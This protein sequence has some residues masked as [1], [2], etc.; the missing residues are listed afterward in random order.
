[1]VFQHKSLFNLVGSM[2]E[3]TLF[4]VRLKIC[5]CI[6]QADKMPEQI[7]KSARAAGMMLKENDISLSNELHFLF[8]FEVDNSYMLFQANEDSWP[9]EML[10]SEKLSLRR[11]QKVVFPKIAEGRYQAQGSYEIMLQLGEFMHQKLSENVNVTDLEVTAV[12]NSLMKREVGKESHVK[13]GSKRSCEG[14]DESGSSG[15]E[16]DIEEGSSSPDLGVPPAKKAK[17]SSQKKDT[18]VAKGGCCASCG[19]ADGDELVVEKIMHVLFR[20]EQRLEKS[21]DVQR[22]ILIVSKKALK[23]VDSMRES[24]TEKS[25]SETVEPSE[26]VYY[27]EKCLTDLGGETPEERVKRVARKLWTKQELS[28]IVIDP[29]KKIRPSETGRGEADIERQELFRKAAK[30]VLGKDYTKKLYRRCVRLV[31]VMGNGYKNKGF[32]KDDDE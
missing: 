12:V 30:T 5:F 28:T 25:A 15:E 19:R 13:A 11:N 6:T 3:L 9:V 18:A 4:S 31:N 2:A 22:D 26:H 16:S 8:Y 20:I 27:N 17:Q 7:R 32:H 10:N 29:Q 1:M 23:E 21:N 14:L 24:D